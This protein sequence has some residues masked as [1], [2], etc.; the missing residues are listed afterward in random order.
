[1]GK[2][3]L[4]YILKF[5]FGSGI[6]WKSDWKYSV[7]TNPEE[8]SKEILKHETFK[9]LAEKLSSFPGIGMAELVSGDHQGPGPRVSLAYKALTQYGT[10]SDEELAE[11]AVLIHKKIL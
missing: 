4:Y 5:R 9:S 10:V 1:M 7:Y 2:E 3:G 6:K 8:R 11:L